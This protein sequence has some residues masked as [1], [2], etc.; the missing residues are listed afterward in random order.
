M[1]FRS[2][3]LLVIIIK[4]SKTVA[5]CGAL[6]ASGNFGWVKLCHVFQK[7]ALTL[8]FISLALYRGDRKQ[9]P[10]DLAPWGNWKQA[11]SLTD[12]LFRQVPSG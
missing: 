7:G 5:A 9:R 1:A 6:M 2:R 10:R 12:Q 8:V 11:P 4:F 3:H